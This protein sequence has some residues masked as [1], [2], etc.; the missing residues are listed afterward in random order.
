MSRALLL[1]ATLL[2]GACGSSTALPPPTIL[3][4][5]PK[6]LVVN[7]RDT[8]VTISLDA[9][10]LVHVDYARE[11]AR[12]TTTAQ[13]WI[14]RE[15]AQL[16]SLDA[17]GTLNVVAPN[18]LQ[19][20]K[21]SLRVVLSD[22]REAVLDDAFEVVTPRN[23]RPLPE[24]DAGEPPEESLDGGILIGDGDLDVTGF[25]FERIGDIQQSGQS[26]TVQIVALGPRANQFQGEVE[27]SLSKKSASV[28][29]TTLQFNNGMCNDEV[30]VTGRSGNLKLTVTHGD[31]AQGTSNGFRVQ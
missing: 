25:R 28:S 13:V 1:L 11:Q 27:L 30:T 15:E 4:V 26:F 17:D 6:L 22:G 12:R 20:G 18:E 31:Y 29:P 16:V 3:S 5:T 2:L 9:V 21:Y 10:L 14:G 8:P 23:G 7:E 19:P 24:G